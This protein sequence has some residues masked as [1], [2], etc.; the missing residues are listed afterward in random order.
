MKIVRQLADLKGRVMNLYLC[1]DGNNEF[2]F[3]EIRND[4]IVEY[5]LLVQKLAERLSVRTLPFLQKISIDNK[6]GLLMNY[7]KDS[8][9][10]CDYKSELNAEQKKELQK[11]VLMDIL[12]GNK[13]RHAANIF[14]NKHLTVFDHDAI[15]VGKERKSSAFIKM[16]VGQK[17]DKQYVAKLEQIIKKGSVSTATALQEYFEFQQEDIRSIKSISDQE[18]YSLLTSLQLD[19]EKKYL[20]IDFLKYRRDNFESLA[21]V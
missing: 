15:L 5:E 2:L 3:K 9:L 4:L 7:L 18:L 19:E 16:D 11:V 13:D 1:S 14:I 20:I 8:V 12:I 17:L 21:F 10:L 6:K